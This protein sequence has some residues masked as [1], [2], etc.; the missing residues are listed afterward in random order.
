MARLGSVLSFAPAGE[1][2]PHLAGREAFR[3]AQQHSRLVRIL[4]KAIPMGCFALLVFLLLRGV[5][6]L[7]FSGPA[8]VSG[9][10][11]IE[12][13]KIVMEKPRLSGF[14]KDGS[15]Y[16]MTAENAVQDLKQPNVVELERLK[17]R[18]Q[19]GAEGWANLAGD[20]G[21]YD[22]KAER[23]QVRGNV[24]VKTETGTDA[25]LQDADIDF[26]TGT[27]VTENATRV[28]TAQGNVI[29][30]RMEVRDSGKHLIF[31]G[32]VSSEFVNNGVPEG[33]P[34]RAP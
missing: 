14:K 29:S 12:G 33:M 34:T 21:T 2:P 17:A 11:R 13:R 32:R 8:E 30:D 9:T 10:F 18:M 4:R 3:A 24:T 25:L 23:L 6:G 19:A 15:S 7:F 16:E 22:S 26:K 20:T 27:V 1:L 31:E 28:K 5:I